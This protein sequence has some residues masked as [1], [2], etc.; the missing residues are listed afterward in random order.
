MR[1]C[2]LILR[3]LTDLDLRL[4]RNGRIWNRRFFLE[5][6]LPREMLQERIGDLEL[7]GIERILIQNPGALK[8]LV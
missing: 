5:I 1:L 2:C 7:F 3:E 8:H 6:E 4:L